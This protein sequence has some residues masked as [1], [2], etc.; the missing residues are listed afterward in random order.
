[1]R[2]QR[3]SRKTFGRLTAASLFVASQRSARAATMLGPVVWQLG[4]LETVQFAGSYVA[5]SRGYYRAQGIDVTIRPGGPNVAVAPLVVAGRALVGDT[6]V[7]NA[8]QARLAGAPIKIVGARWQQ[9]PEVFLS[10]AA[11][12]IRTPA[13]LVGKRL[14]VPSSDLV[15]TKGFLKAAAVDADKVHFVP[16]EDDPAPLVAGE[17]DAYFGYSTDE[18]VTLKV[19]GVPIHVL[20]FADFGS[21]GLF[22]VYIAHEKTLA[23]PGER[24]KLAAFLR[25]EQLGWRDAIRDPDLGVSLA[26]KTYGASLGLDPRQ[27]ALQSRA[28]NTLVTSSETSSH[29]LFWMSPD[30]IAQSVAGLQ[31][32]GMPVRADLFDNSL[33]AEINRRQSAHSGEAPTHA[34]A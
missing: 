33:L 25:G 18:E 23:D 6:T 22:Q 7:S 2:A 17:I 31:R 30:K 20:R 15:D 3:I 11:K 21:N 10:L 26:L 24:A 19:R 27:Q 4:W 14:G 8:A 5:D 9:S 1:M 16:V 32:E 12:P 29:G 13:D 28:T 34:T